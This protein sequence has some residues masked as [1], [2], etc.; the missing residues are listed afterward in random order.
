MLN[1]G[2]L[3]SKSFKHKTT[4]DSITEAEY[5]T[6]SEAVK[7]DMWI[8]KFMTELGVIPSASGPL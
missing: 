3:S 1:G 6:V 7:E 4:I 2:A 5:I 8:K